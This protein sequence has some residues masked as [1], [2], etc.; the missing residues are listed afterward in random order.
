MPFDLLLERT[1][2]RLKNMDDKIQENWERFLNPESLRSNLI[3]ASLYIATFEILKNSIIE[4]I[5]TFFWIGLD[6]SGDIFDPKYQ[7]EVVEKNRSLLYASLEWLRK[8]DVITDDDISLFNRAKAHRNVIAHEITRMLSEGLPSDF[9]E[10]FNEMLYLLN[11]IEIWWVL[12]FEIPINSDLDNEEINEEDIIP[13]SVASIYM[14]LKVALGSDDEA[15]VF[16]DEFVKRTRGTY[17]D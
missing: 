8:T 16:Y 1:D 2:I 6:E 11:K 9:P 5:K 4:R 13:G 10:R 3:L 14:M 15:R 17:K 12:N 7:I